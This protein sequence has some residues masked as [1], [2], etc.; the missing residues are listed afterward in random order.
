L[1]WLSVADFK[2]VCGVSCVR[3]AHP[4]LAGLEY[5]ASCGAGGLTPE[6]PQTSLKI[7]TQTLHQ[8]ERKK[9]ALLE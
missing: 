6:T 3:R 7:L 2:D 8:I 4:A 9:E 5:R 1:A